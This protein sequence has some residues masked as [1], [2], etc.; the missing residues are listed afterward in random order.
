M[1]GNLLRLAHNVLN[2]FQVDSVN[3]KL[4]SE[5]V[6][7]SLVLLLKSFNSWLQKHK[8][9]HY[10]SQLF[11]YDPIKDQIIYQYNQQQQSLKDTS[12]KLKPVY[13]EQQKKRQEGE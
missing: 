13:D 1:F 10:A 7:P 2:A 11:A 9:D 8:Q 6:T 12:D 3:L 4:L 5:T